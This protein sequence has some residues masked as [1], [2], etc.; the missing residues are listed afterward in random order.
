ML[1]LHL[2]LGAVQSILPVHPIAW[3]DP[4]ISPTRG[5]KIKR[6]HTR[7]GGRK[8]MSVEG[9]LQEYKELEKIDFS[10]KLSWLIFFLPCHNGDF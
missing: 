6:V 10:F 3:M 5:Q 4:A 2:Q 1:A 8:R 9:T 7:T